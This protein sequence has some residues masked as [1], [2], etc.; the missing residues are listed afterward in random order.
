MNCAAY[1]EDRID[2]SCMKPWLIDTTLRDGEQAAGVVFSR[3]EKVAMAK[4]L[5]LAGVPEL[6]VGI[7]SMGQEEI[8]NINAIADLGLPTRLLAWCRATRSDLKAAKCCRVHGVHISFPVSD[9]HLRA[10]QK[11]RGWVLSTLKHLVR[12]FRDSFGYMTIGAQDASRADMA[13]LREFAVAAQEAG[14]SRLRI[15]DTVGVLNPMQSYALVR[16]V[17]AATSDLPLEFHAHND[18]GMAVGNSIAALSAGGQAISVT[19]NGIGERAGNA[20][21]EEVVMAL[22]V[23]LRQ[24][25]GID[26]RRLSM[27]SSLVAHASGRSVP[28]NKPIVGP[29]AF[30]HESGIHCAGLAVD[31]RT[32][33]PFPP[34]DVGN[35]SS[36]IFIGRHSGTR[37][38][39]YAIRQRNLRLSKRLLPSLLTEVRAQAAAYKRA[40]TDD[41]FCRI[42]I[43]LGKNAA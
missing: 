27:L 42:V 28:E 32:Y 29:A 25:C 41:E 35:S 18:L 6:E 37:Q 24:D 31:R 20:A 34:E 14:M 9:I 22:H 3:A 19:V 5:A 39:E 36:A 13:F 10:W 23:S 12:E 26:R 7:P 16:E 33:E 4:E 8:D 40:L 17:R 30:H 15:T 21:L 11:S 2:G 1:G 38:L 43:R